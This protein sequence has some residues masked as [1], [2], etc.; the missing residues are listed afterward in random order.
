MKWYRRDG[1]IADDMA[2]FAK[3]FSDPAYKIVK[4]ETLPDGRFLSTVW[5]GLDHSFNQNEKPI[6][7]ETMLFG[8]NGNEEDAAR[9]S[10]EA[11][12]ILGHEAMK[13]RN[14]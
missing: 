5:L 10:T 9:Y 14:T 12:A 1:S 7:F 11:E 4:Q 2:V 6:I 13:A 8:Q 3:R